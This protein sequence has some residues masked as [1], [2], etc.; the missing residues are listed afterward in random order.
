MKKVVKN[1]SSKYLPDE[2]QKI[3]EIETELLEVVQQCCD[4]LSIPFFIAYGTALGA[5]RHGGFIPWDD[6]IDIGMKRCYYEKFIK[7]APEILIKK[8]V[9]LQDYTTEKTAAFA[10]VKVRKDDTVFVEYCNR[11]VKMH[12]GVYIDVFPFDELPVSILDQKRQ[13]KKA[14]RIN[15]IFVIHQTPDITNPPDNVRLFIKAVFR[16]ILHYIVKV[17]PV[18]IIFNKLHK[19]MTKFNGCNSGLYGC[20]FYPGF[21][22]GNLTEKMIT[23]FDTAKF[24]HLNVHVPG[25]IDQ[26]LSSQYGDYMQ[27]PPEE[28]RIGHRPYNVKV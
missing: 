16:R 2:L 11:N 21:Q 25:N 3:K 7:E 8:G 1:Q 4:Q 24:E 18:S 17:I 10:W 26:Y 14:Q 22:A 19:T 12:Q 6:D 20:L 28:K 13:F 9:F 5:V 23:E 15:K 27:L